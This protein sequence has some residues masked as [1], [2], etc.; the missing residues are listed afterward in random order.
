MRRAIV[1]LAIELLVLQ[2]QYRIVGANRGTQKSACILR[3]RGHDNP[4]SGNVRE[5]RLAALAVIDRAAVQI[6]TNGHPDHSRAREPIVRTPA[7]S[8][9]LVANLHHSW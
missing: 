5:G 7:H 8:R 1:R 3:I 6:S 9:H 4:E 2:K